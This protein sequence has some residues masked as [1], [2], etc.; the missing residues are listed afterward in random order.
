MTSLGER[1]ALLLR[2]YLR[3]RPDGGVLRFLFV[4]HSDSES[5]RFY[6]TAAVRQRDSLA[7]EICSML[8]R[9][10]DSQRLEAVERATLENKDGNPPPPDA[11][12]LVFR[13][14]VQCGASV[15]VTLGT[16]PGD[17]VCQSCET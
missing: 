6:R 8:L 2:E 11:T 12:C 1:T 16:L 17:V 7:E 4:G 9:L 5:L 10:T 15:M 13:H 14:C 3:L